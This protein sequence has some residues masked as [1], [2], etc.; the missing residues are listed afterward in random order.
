MTYVRPVLPD[1]EAIER[2]V[3]NRVIVQSPLRKRLKD[4]V[5]QYSYRKLLE[6]LSVQIHSAHDTESLTGTY[7]HPHRLTSLS[8]VWLAGVA[9]GRTTHVSLKRAQTLCFMFDVPISEGCEFITITGEYGHV[10]YYARRKAG[11][12]QADLAAFLNVSAQTV[13]NVERGKVRPFDKLDTLRTCR[14]IKANKTTRRK[15]LKQSKIERGETDTDNSS[16]DLLF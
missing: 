15:L 12:S 11:L 7:P 10:L 16:L 1:F 13:S 9:T 8:R 4:F 6:A 3:S 14:R 5:H 2:K